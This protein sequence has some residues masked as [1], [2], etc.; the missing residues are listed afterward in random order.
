MRRRILLAILSISSI[1]IVLFAFPLAIVTERF[2][3]E[4]A[5]LRLERQAIVAARLVP[6]DY[7]TSQRPDRAGERGR[8]DL[9]LYDSDGVRV[10][11]VGPAD[12]R[13]DDAGRAA[14]PGRRH[15]ERR[16]PGSWPYR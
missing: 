1:A 14:Q 12:R 13:R 9:A 7:R 4:D 2:V 6:G 11:G 5:T 16:A 15:R 10:T 8:P 3:D